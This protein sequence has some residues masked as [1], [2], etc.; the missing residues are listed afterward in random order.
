MIYNNELLKYIL[1]GFFFLF[2]FII[3][4][5]LGFKNS[6]HINGIS[7]QLVKH[8]IAEEDTNKSY[9]SGINNTFSIGGALIS[10]IYQNLS[11]FY[12]NFYENT[13]EKQPGNLQQ[14]ANATGIKEGNT[15]MS[16]SQ[17][18]ASSRHQ[19]QQQQQ[20]LFP[21]PKPISPNITN[22]VPN[23]S[24]SI[25]DNLVSLLSGIIVES[26]QN[27]NPTINNEP[28]GEAPNNNKNNYKE[29][30]V[31]VSGIWN[32]D[33][34]NGNITN[35]NAKFVMITSNGTGFHWHSMGN[36]RTEGKLFLGKDD[37][38]TIEGKLDFFTG[39][40]RTKQPT[41]VLVAI[42]KLET[43]QITLL[44]KDISNHFFRFPLYGTI[45][46]IKI[47]N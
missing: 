31:L 42:N 5:S 20:T 18:E 40:N 2:L 35:F 8:I 46:S 36:L 11:T 19:Q 30:E 25:S 47:K 28:I 14:L 22:V 7:G 15:T 27:G 29:N 4:L 13:A 44:D 16:G 41:E 32:M 6:Q 24:D 39:D 21:I 17:S 23:S 10:T 38:A 33:V 37:T 9:R 12:S 45:D 3:L 1:L 26:I 43:I 34:V